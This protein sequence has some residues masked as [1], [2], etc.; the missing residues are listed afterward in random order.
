MV[1]QKDVTYQ[2]APSIVSDPW[3]SRFICM[4]WAYTPIAG[5]LLYY[6]GMSLSLHY[7]VAPELCSIM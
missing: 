1:D 5:V 2:C 7:G 3:K 6:C 4:F